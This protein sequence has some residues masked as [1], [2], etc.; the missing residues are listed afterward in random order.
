MQMPLARMRRKSENLSVA[1]FTKQAIVQ[2]FLELLNEKPF[3]KITVTDIVNRC[4]INRNT[5]YYYYQDMFAL[6]DELL[7]L[8]IENIVN[9]HRK[10]DTWAEGFLEATTM[11]RENKTAI[12]HLYDSINRDRLEEYLFDLAQSTV[13][14]FIADRAEGLD[15]S[16]QDVHNISVLYTV[17]IEGMML[18]WLH[19]GMKQ[20]PEE[21]L[22]QMEPILRGSTRTLLERA[23]A[24]NN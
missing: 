11:L 24:K 14:Q 20:D 18:E 12:Y 5:F 2:T 4:G 6:V 7:K 21:Y 22:S 8:D 10:A 1:N 17:A 13:T 16:E 9:R 23:A 15:V 19:S 3:A